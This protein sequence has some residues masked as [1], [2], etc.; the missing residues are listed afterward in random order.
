M[1]QLAAL[2]AVHAQALAPMTETLAVAPAA[3]MV[4]AVG[5]TVNVHGADCVIVTV[6]PATII[7]PDRKMLPVFAATE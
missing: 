5:E 2:V 1:I 3:T 6:F 7:D 4:F